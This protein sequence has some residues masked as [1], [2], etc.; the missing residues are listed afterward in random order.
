MLLVFCI[1]SITFGM[2]NRKCVMASGVCKGKK[3]TFLT[4]DLFYSCGKVDSIPGDI[5]S[6]PI[7]LYICNLNGDP[8][9]ICYFCF[10]FLYILACIIQVFVSSRTPDVN[11]VQAIDT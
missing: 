2:G 7:F 10:K 9:R 8:D 11:H 6:V 3:W 4:E 5:P 1:N